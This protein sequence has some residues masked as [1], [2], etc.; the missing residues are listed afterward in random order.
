MFDNLKFFI[1]RLIPKLDEATWQSFIALQ[2]VKQYHKGDIISEEGKVNS[3]VSFIEEGAV[4][5]YNHLDNK[6]CIYNFFFEHEYTGDYESFLTRKPALYGLEAAED[7]ILLQMHYNGLQ[8]MYENHPVFERVGRL[9]AENQFLRLT[10]RN[11]SL[12]AESPEIRYKK[13]LEAKPQVAQ[14]IPQYHIASYLGITPEALSRIR[15][16]IQ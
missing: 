13:L 6:R 10:T 5:V 1:Q 8:K 14:R 15:K 16:R 4:L 12:L 3:I 2:Q 7:C 9:V 11:A